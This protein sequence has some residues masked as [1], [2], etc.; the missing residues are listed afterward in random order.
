[1][2]RRGE[3]TEDVEVRPIVAVTAQAEQEGL[4]R[5]GDRQV[6]LGP[7]ARATRD[8]LLTAAYEQF[9]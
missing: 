8:R 3:K 1:M 2:A 5:D 4:R 6:P 7:K 9:S